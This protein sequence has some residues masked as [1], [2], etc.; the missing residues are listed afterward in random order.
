MR[1]FADGDALCDSGYYHGVTEA[2][3]GEMG[4][5]EAVQEARTVCADVDGPPGGGSQRTCWHGLGHG[6]MHVLDRD[7]RASLRGCDTL[8]PAAAR[9]ECYTGVFMENHTSA[10]HP[11]RSSLRPLEPLYPCTALPRLY[12]AACYERQ[13]SYALHVSN[14]DFGSVFRRCA[15]TGDG[16]EA[17]CR[18]ALG[19]DVAAETRDF[20]AIPEQ[21]S[22]RRR[23]C[24]AGGDREARAHC[25]QGVVD[26]VLRD[27][28]SEPVVEVDAFCAAWAA[29]GAQRDYAACVRA[30]T[31]G[32]RRLAA[33][34]AG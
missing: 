18:R 25:I 16:F 4:A 21:A 23:L 11:E 15:E 14:G 22:V 30:A 32:Y 17:T 3:M 26:V 7:L 9:R 5:S 27:P 20:A 8:R 31:A 33:R 6:F 13:T 10:D 2:V 29:P 28:G 19:G 1:A 34:L 24:E 12:K